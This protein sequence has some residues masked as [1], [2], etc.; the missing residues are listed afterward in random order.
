MKN[1]VLVNLVYQTL[2]NY[3]KNSNHNWLEHVR[4]DFVWMD[5]VGLFKEDLLIEGYDLNEFTYETMDS[6]L[7]KMG[8][9]RIDSPI[10]MDWASDEGF[11]YYWID[12]AEG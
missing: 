2:E 3:Y 1:T 11:Y 5:M 6:E 12:Y 4:S 10:G 7:E 8:A 9:F